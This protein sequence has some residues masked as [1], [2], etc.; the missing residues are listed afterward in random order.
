M[1]K[2]TVPNPKVPKRSGTRNRDTRRRVVPFSRQML[3]RSFEGRFPGTELTI[4]GAVF[5]LEAGGSIRRVDG[6]HNETVA[7]R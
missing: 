4:R 3:L 1:R 2:P 5:R 7:Q 6:G